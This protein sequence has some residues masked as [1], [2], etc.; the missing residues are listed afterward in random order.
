MLVEGKTKQKKK[1]QS[2]T[3]LDNSLGEA[4]MIPLKRICV[5]FGKKNRRNPYNCF[6]E[7]LF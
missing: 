1:S 3:S 7:N 4:K 5:I 2:N 6:R